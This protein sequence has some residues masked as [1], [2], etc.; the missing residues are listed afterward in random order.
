VLFIKECLPKL[1]ESKG[2]II[3]IASVDG[4]VG[5]PKMAAY[6][7]SKHAVVGLSESLRFEL[8]GTGVSVSCI[9]PGKVKTNFFKNES[10]KDA[11]FAEDDGVVPSAVARAVDRAIHERS[12]MY[13][14][15]SSKRLELILHRILPE[16]IARKITKRGQ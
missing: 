6:S 2:T 7:A 16:T 8:E 13:C 4:L 5:T 14:V 9:C 10:F 11:P 1:K 3:N 15:P 12:F